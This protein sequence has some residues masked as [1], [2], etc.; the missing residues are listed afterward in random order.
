VI[1][2][3]RSYFFRIES[4]ELVERL[5]SGLLARA[6][7]AA[8]IDALFRAAHTLKGAA[9][10]VERGLVADLSHSLED[11]LSH[12][13]DSGEPLTD[14]ETG[15]LLALVDAI[16][17][18]LAEVRRASMAPGDAPAANRA[19]TDGVRVRSDD[20]DA[21]TYGLSA[22]D[23]QGAEVRAAASSAVDMKALVSRLTLL[24]AQ[25]TTNG[26]PSP[27]LRAGLDELL[28]LITDHSRSL[29]G[30]SDRLDTELR[31]VGKRAFELRL[32]SLTEVV[33][34]LE[35]TVHDAS[36]SAG[37]AVRFVARGTD[38]R[39]DVNVLGRLRSALVHLVRNAIAH[40]IESRDDRLDRGKDPTGLVEVAFERRGGRIGM[41]VRDDGCGLARA[42]IARAARLR[43]LVESEDEALLDAEEL[44]FHPGLS[45]ARTVTDL[46]GRGVGL[47]AVRGTIEDC[48]G[49]VR[50]RSIE[51][52]G[53][54][55]EIEVPVSLSATRALVVESSGETVLIPIDF[56]VSTRKIDASQIVSDAKGAALIH[57]D[58][59]LPLRD[60]SEVV[61][62]ESD[63]ELPR[64]AV[65]L[66]TSNGLVALGVKALRGTRDVV[67]RPLPRALGRSRRFSGASI[68]R[69]G[70]PRLVLDP[71]G[72][73]L[74]AVRPAFARSRTGLRGK[75]VLVIDDSLTT[76]MLEQSILEAVGFEVDVAS[77][78]EEGLAMASAREYGLFV[79]D[80]EMPG[81]NGYE[82]TRETRSRNDL[83]SVPVIMVTSLDS[84]ESRRKG[85]EAGVSTYI[86]KGEFDQSTFLRAVSELRV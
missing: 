9:R 26:M 3:D 63:S 11:V 22:L 46:A 80:V 38:I 43:G 47:D 29:R 17:N 5:E 18:E 77:S 40:G 19:W 32:V 70:V 84:E 48:K 8:S 42:E 31:D 81:M 69:G 54:T 55:F 53:T 35:R 82:F 21:L 67:L 6:N 51:G 30:A 49:T 23:V 14:Q 10:A 13:R 15:E 78:A 1:A 72:L 16:R 75:P 34:E 65:V 24:A 79:C 36:Q 52:V 25:P 58:R 56:I 28:A 27:R 4:T 44:I 68:D 33:P 83:A 71:E 64:V 61:G 12:H 50:V 37:R 20:V 62:A 45:T 85:R 57:D 76:R 86:V 60:L 7:D 39:I 74:D 73:S 2:R 66:R 59:S 41:T